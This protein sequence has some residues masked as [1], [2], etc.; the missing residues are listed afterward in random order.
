MSV[1][2]THETISV[3]EKQRT[4]NFILFY[5]ASYTFFSSLFLSE[6]F[7]CSISLASLNVRGPEGFGQ[8]K[9]FVFIL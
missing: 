2:R 3:I 4:K 9:G 7:N 8:K 5:K 6:M 1:L